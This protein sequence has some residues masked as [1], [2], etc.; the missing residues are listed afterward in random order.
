M[1][2]IDLMFKDKLESASNFIPWKMRVTPVLIENGFWDFENSA[3][4][5]LIDATKLVIHNQKNMK[6]RRI[7]LDGVKD[8]LIPYMPKKKS[9]REMFEALRNLSR[10]I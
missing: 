9:I 1:V 5:P 2:A 10:V 7:I 6:V 8:Y 4:T 3:K